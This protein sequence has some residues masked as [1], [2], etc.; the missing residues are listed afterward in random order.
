MTAPDL[1]RLV[2]A[3]FVRHLAVEHNASPHTTKAYRDALKLLL[4]FAADACHRPTA[5]LRLDDLSPDLILRFL[6]DL[7]TTRRNS[8]RT[9]NARLARLR[10]SS[11]R[12]RR[13]AEVTARLRDAAALQ[14]QKPRRARMCNTETRSLA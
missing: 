13:C 9:R 2:T 5:S 11:S 7:E 1:A 14:A 6:A 4:R 10:A 8:V 3:F 12:A